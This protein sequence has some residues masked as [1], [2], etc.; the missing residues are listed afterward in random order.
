MGA[1]RIESEPNSSATFNFLAQN[2]GNVSLD[3]I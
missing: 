3:L 1:N 2:F